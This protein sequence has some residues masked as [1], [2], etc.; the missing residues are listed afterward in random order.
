MAGNTLKFHKMNLESVL[1]GAVGDKLTSISVP[2]N[3]E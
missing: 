2:M 1:Q 3:T